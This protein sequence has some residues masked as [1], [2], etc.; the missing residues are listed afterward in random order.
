MRRRTPSGA[1]SGS[2]ASRETRIGFACKARGYFTVSDNVIEDARGVADLIY[3][4][5]L[6]LWQ[7]QHLSLQPS[8]FEPHLRCPACK[9]DVIPLHVERMDA[10]AAYEHAEAQAVAWMER[11]A[12]LREAA[13]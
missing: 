5:A 13:R 4:R 9:H 10:G 6:D 8:S 1:R 3:P 12:R 2:V 7:G 11:A